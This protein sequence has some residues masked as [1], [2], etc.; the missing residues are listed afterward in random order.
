MLV[1]DRHAE[2]QRL[3]R[4]EEEQKKRAERRIK[5]PQNLGDLLNKITLANLSSGELSDIILGAIENKTIDFEDPKQTASAKQKLQELKQRGGLDKEQLE[6]VNKALKLV[7]QAGQSYS[8]LHPDFHNLGTQFPA[9]PI[10]TKRTHKG[11]NPFDEICQRHDKLGFLNSVYV[12]SL[13]GKGDVIDLVKDAIKR[14]PDRDDIDIT[15]TSCQSPDEQKYS[16]G[17]VVRKFGH[18]FIN[19]NLA[20]LIT[21]QDDLNKLQNEL[22]KEFPDK[23]IT[24]H[25]KRAFGAGM[26]D[27]TAYKFEPEI[28]RNKT[29]TKTKDDFLITPSELAKEINPRHL[30]SYRIDEHPQDTTTAKSLKVQVFHCQGGMGRSVL[31]A[32]AYMV[33]ILHVTPQEASLKMC[34]IRS[35]AK[36]LDPFESHGRSLNPTQQKLMA[37]FCIEAVKLGDFKL[38]ELSHNDISFLMLYAGKAHLAMLEKIFS[39]PENH[40]ILEAAANDFVEQL[41]EKKKFRENLVNSKQKGT[42][43]IN[44]INYIKE[45]SEEGTKKTDLI[46]KLL[47]KTKADVFQVHEKIPLEALHIPSIKV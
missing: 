20:E 8:E 21:S 46:S 12:A 17:E 11:R 34:S 19:R 47:A 6:L 18:P 41:T 15:I 36:S 22:K 14:N 35:A 27:H 40:K 7:V 44:I 16:S 31:L 29:A 23:T 37:N 42:T 28:K 33:K 5:T 2:R 38:K 10:I 1:A 43:I 3:K 32:Y 39:V 13:M 25:Y 45:S 30:Q 24:L 9:I 26:P 4:E